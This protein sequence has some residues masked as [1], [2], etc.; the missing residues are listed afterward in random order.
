[1]LLF[2]VC[3]LFQSP[4]IDKMTQLLFF[5][6]PLPSNM[7]DFWVNNWN[8]LCVCHFFLVVGLLFFSE[9]HTVAS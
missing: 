4:R 2:K 5:P 3:P 7:G 8:V 1:M 9:A 6:L